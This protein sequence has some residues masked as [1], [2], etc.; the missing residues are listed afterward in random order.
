MS[1]ARE[2]LNTLNYRSHRPNSESMSR[3]TRRIRVPRHPH[4]PLR[5]EYEA[6]TTIFEILI[7][8]FIL[9]VAIAG[10][11]GLLVNASQTSGASQRR[12]AATTLAIGEL[13][14]IRSW[15]FTAVGIASTDPAYTSEF[16]GQTTVTNSGENRLEA[17][18]STLKDGF[19][20]HVERHVTWAPITVAEATVARGYKT[21]TIGV[22]WTDRTGSH[23]VWH[24]TGLYEKEPSP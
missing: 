17:S 5:G 22:S 4:R 21:V 2:L 1:L 24:Q 10:T 20:Y 14:E 8:T 13:E 3:I 23:T 18:G 16:R 15:P 9:G 7:A 11:A 6:G 19:E 12:A